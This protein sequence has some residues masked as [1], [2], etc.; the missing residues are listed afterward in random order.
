LFFKGGKMKKYSK[1]LAMLMG[2]ASFFA[3][4]ATKPVNAVESLDDQGFFARISAAPRNLW[5]ALP[6]IDS[7]KKSVTAKGTAYAKKQA[8][9]F[10]DKNA[11]Q[12]AEVATKKLHALM[13]RHADL[14]IVNDEGKHIGFIEDI[15]PRVG[16]NLIQKAL[17]VDLDRDIPGVPIFMAKAVMNVIEKE[18]ASYLEASVQ[19]NLNTALT[20]LSMEALQKGLGLVEEKVNVV[21]TAKKETSPV[22]G[23]E[24]EKTIKS[25]LLKAT[26]I[27]E[28]L[29]PE[30]LSAMS[31][32]IMALQANLK[33][34][35][36]SWLNE[37][38]NETAT[39]FL[40]QFV[41]Q[42]AEGVLRK[43]EVAAGAV[44]TLAVGAA[45]G[46]TG[47]VVAAGLIAGDNYIAEGV[48]AEESYMR[49]AL[50]WLTSYDTRKEEIQKTIT[51][52]TTNRINAGIDNVLKKVGAES[53]VLTEQDYDFVYGKYA[54]VEDEFGFTN[55]EKVEDAYS[56][57]S[58]GNR[59]A[60]NF[61]KRATAVFQQAQGAVTQVGTA[62]KKNA[63]ILAETAGDFSLA[64]GP[65]LAYEEVEPTQKEIL[66]DRMIDALER[67][68]VEEIAEL[69][70]QTKTLKA[71]EEKH[72][73]T[74]SW[75]KFW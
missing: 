54:A 15:N 10:L 32:L 50:K 12:V 21:L 74:K 51:T 16:R 25:A 45:T 72:P 6:G 19:K 46:G 18:A 68:D 58:F 14:H 24:E 34:K 1:S 22:P 53:L 5:K 63:P 36:H 23:V 41:E 37:V 65:G 73:D 13:Y 61:K 3:I 67:R 26:P 59:I 49:Q 47:A 64:L 8:E 4:I 31:E 20:Q 62:V 7:V 44:T 43:T 57:T 40:S 38:A 66:Q 71:E 56:L 48:P 2:S 35:I 9:A 42:T 75:W 30:D 55:L 60:D 29:A 70:L 33:L 11:A 52:A 17:G 39:A 28:S 27:N 69:F